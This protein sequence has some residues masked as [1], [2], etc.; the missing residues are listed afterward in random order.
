[1]IVP[2]EYETKL[3]LV[4]RL[5]IGVITMMSLGGCAESASPSGISEA[6]SPAS[7]PAAAL[8]SDMDPGRWRQVAP[9]P[10]ARSEVATVALTGK[11][12]VIGGLTPGGGVTDKVEAYDPVSDSWGE[13][14]PLPWARHHAAAAVV[15]GKIYLIGGFGGPNNVLEYDPATNTWDAMAGMPA[16]RGALVAAAVEGRIY[17]I[18]GLGHIGGRVATVEVY[19]P[20]SDT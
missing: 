10:T 20:N 6:A 13:R 5:V 14:A 9:L 8:P 1:M 12:Y 18:G 17:A 15:G 19:D 4:A 7:P 16:A 11:V 3:R 2:L